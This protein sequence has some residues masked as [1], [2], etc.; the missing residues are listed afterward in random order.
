MT[1]TLLCLALIGCASAPMGPVGV[2]HQ[3]GKVQSPEALQADCDH[4]NA[5]ACNNLGADYATGH[6]GP[7]DSAR[8]VQLFTRACDAGDPTAATT[9]ASPPPKPLSPDSLREARLLRFPRT[10]DQRRTCLCLR[11]PKKRSV[12]VRLG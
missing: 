7:M 9:S 8:A 12:S 2:P 1:R 11:L 5:R 10:S 4:G 3:S 6:D